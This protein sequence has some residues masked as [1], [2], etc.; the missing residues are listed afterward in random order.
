MVIVSFAPVRGYMDGSPIVMISSSS[1]TNS[2]IT[3]DGFSEDHEYAYDGASVQ[4]KMV[5]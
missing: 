1:H 4:S 5:V 2:E 3:G